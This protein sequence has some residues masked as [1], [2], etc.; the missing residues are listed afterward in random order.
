M[1]EFGDVSKV[2]KFEL[3]SDDYEKKT[4]KVH[5]FLPLLRFKKKTSKVEIQP[6]FLVPRLSKGIHEEA[7][8]WSLQ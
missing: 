3:S 8:P 4:G 7:W 2:E 1:G 5:H 6:Y